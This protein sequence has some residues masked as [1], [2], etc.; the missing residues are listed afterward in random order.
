M[1]LTC[2]HC[3]AAFPFIDTTR[4]P[5]CGKTPPFPPS[6]APEPV[7]CGKCGTKLA[8]DGTCPENLCP[9]YNEKPTRTR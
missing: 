6:P 1:T 3:R 8:K 7:Y 2:P 5:S 4:C 9:F